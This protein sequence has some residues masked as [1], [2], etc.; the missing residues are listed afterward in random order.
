MLPN[1]RLLD[2]LHLVDYGTLV[3]AKLAGERLLCLVTRFARACA[4][5]TFA[6]QRGIRT[7]TVSF[8]V[9]HRPFQQSRMK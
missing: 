1:E 3:V 4:R 2:T 7:N 9:Y 8:P 6:G 5:E